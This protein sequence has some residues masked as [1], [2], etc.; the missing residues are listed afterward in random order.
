[1]A[2]FSRQNTPRNEDEMELLTA[3]GALLSLPVLVCILLWWM[4]TNP[5]Q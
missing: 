3:L 1:M 2:G 4:I 5:P